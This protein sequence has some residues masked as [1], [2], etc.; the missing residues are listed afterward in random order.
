MSESGDRSKLQFGFSTILLFMLA[1]ATWL[2]AYR[3]Q[4]QLPELRAAVQRME[5]LQ[6]SEFEVPDSDHFAGMKRNPTWYDENIWDIF[7]PEGS[8]F[9]LRLATQQVAEQGV[10]PIDLA[11]PLTSGKHQIELKR[12]KLVDDEWVAEILVDGQIV[13]V[14]K[15][16]KTWN[17]GKGSS[18][19]GGGVSS[20]SH[21]ADAPFVLFR[22]RWHVEVGPNT[23]RAPP[24]PC[25]GLLLWVQQ[26]Q[27]G[28]PSQT[29]L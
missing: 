20:S 10:A 24:R 8:Q 7:V 2:A 15:K 19:G 3:F 6:T 17:P 22:R 9:E 18:G 14:A 25:N 16:P 4:R 29:A 1:I 12:P 11:A 21:N 5:S 13:L 23:F 27:V 28:E 26:Q